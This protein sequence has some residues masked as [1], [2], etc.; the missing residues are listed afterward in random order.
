MEER[1]NLEQLT[2]DISDVLYDS[3]NLLDILDDVVDGERKAYFLVSTLQ[4][5]IK[6]AFDDVETC[7]QMI[8][9]PD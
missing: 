4:K 6:K 2:T 7:R 3:I 9:I 8:S 1:K 5:N